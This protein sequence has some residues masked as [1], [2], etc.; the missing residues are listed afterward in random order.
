MTAIR[1]LKPTGQLALALFLL[2]V[3]ALASHAMAATAGAA[4]GNGSSASGQTEAILVA[5]VLLL[6]I[7]GRVLGEIMQRLRQ[8]ALMGQLLAGIVLGPSLFGWIWPQGHDFI[9]PDNPEQ[10][11][12]ID[13][14][15]Q[16]GILLLLL[17]TGMETDLKLVRKSGWAAVTISLA[18]I[19]L[20]FFCGFMLGQFLPESMLPPGEARLVPSLFLGTALSI[21]SIKIVAMVVREMNFM[22]RNLGQVI[23]ATAIMEDTVGWVIIAITFGI[24]GAENAGGSGG[25]LDL[26]S[27]VMTGGGVVLFLLFAFTIGR[28]LVFTAI[29]WANDTF[30]SEFPVITMILVITGVMA[31]MTHMLGVRTV[32]GAFMAGVLIG[33]SPILT[34][35]IQQQLRGVITAFFMPVFFGM[36]GLSADLTI[37]ADPSLALWTAGLV[38]VASIGKFS[39]AFIGAE[40][41]GL[42]RREGLAL[43]CAMNARGSTEV[44]VASIGLSMGALTQNLYTMVV[45]MAVLTTMAMP[46][47]LRA[48]LLRLPMTPEEKVRIEREAVDEKG[49]VPQLERL[50]LAADDGPVGRM[51]ARLAG[52][53]AGAHGMPVTILKLEADLRDAGVARKTEEEI[54]E[55]DLRDLSGKEVGNTDSPDSDRKELSRAQSLI[56][57]AAELKADPL[58]REVKR[59]ARHSAAKVLA[60][61]AEP[62]PE[63]VHLTAKVPLDAP[64]EVVR[65]EARK[66]YDLLFVGVQDGVEPDGSFAPKVTQLA[67][68]FE[69]PLVVLGHR[70]GGLP[71]LTFRSTLLV[72][73][74][75]SPQSRRAAEIALAVARGTGARV[76]ALFVSQTDGHSRTRLR[77]ERVLKDMTELGERYDVRV[78]TQ[79]SPRAAAADA[80]LRQARRNYAMIVMGVSVRPGEDLFF[81]N[82]ATAVLKD[83]AGPALMVAT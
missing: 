37:L 40:L 47:M 38:A 26:W 20:P 62:D 10:K 56:Q 68:G 61:E 76:H 23:V 43:G 48:A 9:F 49:F 29:R 69:G 44:I 35:H 17:L 77:E 57:S 83:W 70:A 22:R 71:P 45:T 7:V 82:T 1:S 13:G 78:T 65:D 42:N 24:A 66:G 19:A 80:I 81:G 4:A 74:N 50:L 3:F 54:Q 39:G 75:G 36:S 14:L 6:M 53:L 73:V 58:A 21:S 32:L 34:D 8:P 18:G 72:P 60:D 30:R 28:W 46:P 16:F 12:M 52:L 2:C 59:G 25:G 64:A 31:L 27:I 55:G 15:S 5:Q 67:A 51:A 63:K 79:I 11:G 33:E 41:G